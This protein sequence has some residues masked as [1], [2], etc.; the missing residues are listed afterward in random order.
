[1]LSVFAGRVYL[2]TL[3][4]RGR[5]GIEAFD[6]DDRSLGVAPDLPAAIAM[7]SSAS[8]TGGAT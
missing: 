5:S 4:S 1:M 2:G 3:L 6:V 8:R 7:L